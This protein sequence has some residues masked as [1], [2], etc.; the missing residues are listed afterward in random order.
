MVVA[1][2]LE[3]VALGNLRAIST[4]ARREIR[5]ASDD[6]LDALLFRLFEKLDRAEHV[7]V[8]GDRDRIHARSL[9]MIDQRTN[10][11]GAVEQ[12]ELGMYVK[13][14]ETHQGTPL[15]TAQL[16]STD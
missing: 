16:R 8:V 15:T 4:L 12:T 14:R 5:L 13:M 7:A 11:V 10:L 2:I 3:V 1:A 6:R 9:G